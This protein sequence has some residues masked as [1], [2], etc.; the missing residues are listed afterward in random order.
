M[1]GYFLMDGIKLRHSF[2]KD[3]SLA[4]IVETKEFGNPC[5]VERTTLNASSAS[6]AAIFI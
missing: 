4:C 2:A 1:Y 5:S 3:Q 6:A